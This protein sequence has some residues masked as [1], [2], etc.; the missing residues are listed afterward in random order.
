MAGLAANNSTETIDEFDFAN[1]VALAWGPVVSL[2]GERHSLA[3]GSGT[4]NA[5]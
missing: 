2:R 4:W 1:T 5:D 3:T